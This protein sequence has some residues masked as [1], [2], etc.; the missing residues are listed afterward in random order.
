MSEQKIEVVLD[1]QERLYSRNYHDF[2]DCQLLNGEEKIIYLSLKRFI[3]VKLD[4][5]QVYP[6]IETIQN[7]TGWGNKK[8]IKYIK[9]LVKKGVDKSKFIYYQRFF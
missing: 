1:K 4:N 7:M 9:S 2:M 8:V 6:T 3:N 5:G